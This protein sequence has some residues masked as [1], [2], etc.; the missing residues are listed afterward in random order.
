[1]GDR[2]SRRPKE[3]KEMIV[4]GMV[5]QIKFQVEECGLGNARNKNEQMER[6]GR[7]TII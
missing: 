5:K 1:M 7:R 2:E 4:S 3:N 6:W